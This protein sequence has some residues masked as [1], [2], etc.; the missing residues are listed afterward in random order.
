MTKKELESILLSEATPR[1]MISLMWN[2][3][4]KTNKYQEKKREGS[5]KETDS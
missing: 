2:F 1:N 5:N 4:N 3:R